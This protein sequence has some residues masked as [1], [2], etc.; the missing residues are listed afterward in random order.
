M[1]NKY[2]ARKDYIMKCLK[3]NLK[4]DYFSFSK[5]RIVVRRFLDKGG[6]IYSL[7]VKL[8]KCA[9]YANI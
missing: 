8:K 9:F 1:L 5:I 2:D 6:F 3:N 7:D 4:F